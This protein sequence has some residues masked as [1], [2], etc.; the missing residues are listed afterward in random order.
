M[1][2]VIVVDDIQWLD[3]TSEEF[4]NYFIGWISNAQVLLLLLY[5]QEYSHSW[6]GKSFYNQIAIPPLSREESR[7]FICAL[8][9]TKEISDRLESL[10]F[11]RTSGNPLFMEELSTTLIEDKTIAKENGQWQLKDTGDLLHVPETIQGIIAGRMDRLGDNTKTTMQM[12]S[13]I[14]RS[15][16]FSLLQR[17]TGM[18]DAIKDYLLTLRNLEFINEKTLFPELEYLF[19]N[20]ITREVAYNSLLLNHRKKIHGNIGLAIE[21]MY[22][23]QPEAF[24]EILAFHFAKSDR[25]GKAV[26]YL[27]ASGDKAMQ[28]HAAFEAFEFY[29]RAV[30]LSHRLDRHENGGGAGLDGAQVC[31]YY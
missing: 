13:V 9:G 1:P 12:A 24:Y 11:N 27:K 3:K 21:E 25:H 31:A 29:K 26:R 22:G 10:I 7:R 19:K 23:E 2:L 6:G 8:L 16:G 14:G 4:L 18:D 15:F 30:A 5:R 28:N 17:L 20:M